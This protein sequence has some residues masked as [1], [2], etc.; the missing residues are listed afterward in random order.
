MNRRDFLGI[1]ALG[2]VG[3]LAAGARNAYA[4]NSAIEIEEATITTLQSAMRSG[5]LTSEA[6]TSW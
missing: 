3:I 6:I 1:T 5:R 4:G 2:S